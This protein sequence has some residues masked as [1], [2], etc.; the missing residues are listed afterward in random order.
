MLENMLPQAL[1]GDEPASSASA[2]HAGKDADKS[3]DK[4]KGLTIRIPPPSE[5]FK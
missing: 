1:R 5:W 3:A 4:N 2:S